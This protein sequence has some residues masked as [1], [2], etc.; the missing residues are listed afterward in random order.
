MFRILDGELYKALFALC[1][2]FAPRSGRCIEVQHL[3]VLL[4]FARNTDFSTFCEAG[5]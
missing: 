3:S 4:N 2:G 1:Y 5:K